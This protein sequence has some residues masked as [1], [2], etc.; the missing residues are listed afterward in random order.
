MANNLVMRLLFTNKLHNINIKMI[1]NEYFSSL[2]FLFLISVNTVEK[3]LD[4]CDV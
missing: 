3:K 4:R 1:K 2:F